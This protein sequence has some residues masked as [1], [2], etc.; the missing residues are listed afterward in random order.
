MPR[1]SVIIPA[2]NAA[3]YV[4]AAVESILGQTF[5]DFEC[6]VIDDGSTDGTGEILD[7]IPDPRLRIVHRENRG[8]V[9]T[10]NEAIGL[11]TSPLVAFMDADDVALPDRLAL[12]VAAMDARDGLVLYGGQAELIDPVGRPLGPMPVPLDHDRI[13][14]ANMS[15][16]HALW[17][18]SLMIRAEAL[19]Q[20]GGFD[21]HY[22]SAE[23]LDLWLRLAEIGEIANGPET[24]LR[25]RLHLQSAGHSER[26]LQ[27]HFAW[28]A[29][30]SA[31]AR[32][33]EA[34][35]L[36]EPDRDGGPSRTDIHAKWGWWA[37][38]GGHLSTARHYALAALR[39]EP[40]RRD[41][42]RLAYCA[43]RGR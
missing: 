4:R 27:R 22:R 24:V 1:V 38:R 7:A 36:A 30:K 18:P 33:G 31:A 34:F 43:L 17:N 42:W 40:L 28:Q 12:Q 41:R 19:E 14:A 15:G 25:Y 3:P 9:A 2:Y 32:R 10:R 11:A 23:D 37:L 35:D 20:V 5:R 16:K 8:V 39:A 21:P 6:I 26:G 29:A 13:D